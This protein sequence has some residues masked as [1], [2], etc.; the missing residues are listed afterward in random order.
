VGPRQDPLTDAQLIA[1]IQRGDSA[2]FDQLYFRYRDWAAS[3]AL[4]FTASQ[5]DAQ[6]VT[7]ETFVYLAGKCARLTLTAK[8]TTFLYPVVRNLSLAVLRRRRMMIND[9]LLLSQAIAH[10]PGDH[11]AG[12]AEL[13]AVM[14]SL[15]EAQREAILMRF[16]DGFSLEEIAQA[17]AIPLGTVKSRLRLG[18]AALRSSPRVRRYFTET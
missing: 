18:F 1:A 7:Q 4:R 10:P 3:L 15:P 5:S 11:D 13:A 2:A 8:M 9:E 17:L 14:A 6:D 16:V 12:R